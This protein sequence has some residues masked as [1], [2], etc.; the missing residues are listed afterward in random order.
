MWSI[1]DLKKV[2]KWAITLKHIRYKEGL[3]R[4]KLPIFGFRR[5]SDTIIS[6]FLHFLRQWLLW[7]V[8]V[9]NQ[10]STLIK[11]LILMIELNKILTDRYCESIS[12]ELELHNDSLKLVNSRC[13]YDLRKYSIAVGVVNSPIWNSLLDSVIN[14]NDV[15]TFKNRLD[16]FWAT[17]NW[18][19]R[20]VSSCSVNGD[21]TFLWIWSKFD[22][23]NLNPKPI[24]INL[25]KIDYVHE[26]NSWPKICTNRL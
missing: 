18:S 21:I 8:L 6:A 13:H 2:T 9:P 7:L 26:T 16:R 17:K 22:P 25:C 11:T 19:Q 3:Q 14:A 5:I 24:T 23:Q 1:K 15:D 10:N 12:L 4:L 20:N